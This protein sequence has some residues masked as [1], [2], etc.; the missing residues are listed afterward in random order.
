[1]KHFSL[2]LL[3]FLFLSQIEGNAQVEAMKQSPVLFGDFTQGSVVQK[4]RMVTKVPLNYDCI[5][6]EMHFIQGGEQLILDNLDRIESVTVGDRRFIP[7]ANHFL[8]V[9]A[10]SDY[11]LYI[12]WKTKIA[13]RGKKGAM[14]QVTHGGTIT[15]ADV[16]L[17]RHE[18]PDFK[19]TNVY[20]VIPQNTYY[21]SVDGEKMKKFNTLKA[22]CK[23]FPQDKEASIREFV[24]AE[25]I[26]M[27]KPEH[28][29]KLV[30]FISSQ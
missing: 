13:N 15:Q 2:C 3:F 5:N 29:Y 30:R 18:A 10:F 1:M 21:L 8:E 16:S 4:N 28:I 24:T 27:Q 22:F 11:T 20:E 14:G 17:M 19:D 9:I 12:D 7:H 26:D 6:Q 23:F 25:K